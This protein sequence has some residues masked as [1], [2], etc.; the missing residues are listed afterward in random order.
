MACVTPV[1]LFIG[2]VCASSQ[3]YPRQCDDFANLTKLGK[4]WVSSWAEERLHSVIKTFIAGIILGIAAVFVALHFIPVVDQHREASIISV[5]PNGGN[6]ETFH[7]NV[8]MDRIMV[9]AQGRENALPPGLEWP[10]DERFNGLQS[11]IFKLRNSRDTVVGVASRLAVNDE[12]VGSVIEWVLHLPARGSLFVQ[13]QPQTVDGVRRVGPIAA[14][15]REFN[16]LI[17]GMS[18]RWVADTSTDEG[19]PAGRI[20]LVAT[21]VA[22]EDTSDHE[23][24]VEVPAQ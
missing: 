11:E 4:R 22:E 10:A 21:F 7:I 6:L 17:G 14:G 2:G 18:E 5:T 20:E 8:P 19:A 13:L 9:G 12:A 3:N 15:T 23:G 16:S 1:L 24:L